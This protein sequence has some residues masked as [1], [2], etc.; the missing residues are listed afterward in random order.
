M[1]EWRRSVVK[2]GSVRGQAI[3]LFQELNRTGDVLCEGHV[4]HHLLVGDVIINDA[5]EEN[6]KKYIHTWQ[7]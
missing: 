7:G 4:I 6:G 3:K 1:L 2:Y 5:A